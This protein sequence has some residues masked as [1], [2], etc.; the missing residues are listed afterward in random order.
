MKVPKKHPKK[1][2]KNQFWDAFWPPKTL[3]NRRK[4]D[5]K[6]EYRPGRARR[7]PNS[8]GRPSAKN[9]TGQ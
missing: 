8:R 9:P 1:L 2:P 5:Q 6:I 4:I 3:Q 7:G